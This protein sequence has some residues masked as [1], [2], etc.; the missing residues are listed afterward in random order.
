MDVEIENLV[1]TVNTEL[2]DL[3]DDLKNI[4]TLLDK[5]NL[6]LID[7]QSIYLF[8]L[9]K[10]GFPNQ[11]PFHERLQIAVSNLKSAFEQI[12]G[13]FDLSQLFVTSTLAFDFET[14]LNL[15]QREFR[16]P[17]NV[18]VLAFKYELEKVVDELKNK[19]KTE[20]KR[21]EGNI[22]QD[23]LFKINE[24][25]RESNQLKS[26]IFKS[27]GYKHKALS[28]SINK[29]FDA[30]FVRL[31]VNRDKFLKDLKFLIEKKCL[32]FEEKLAQ[33]NEDLLWTLKVYQRQ[34][35]LTNPEVQQGQF[36]FTILFDNVAKALI[37]SSSSSS[38]GKKRREVVSC[39]S[40]SFNFNS[41]TQDVIIR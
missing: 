27:L 5:A 28:I 23:T 14:R 20:L 38:L 31:N 41:F 2:P 9:M 33:A 16:T 13:Q 25:K 7:E 36:S 10:K 17:Q 8:D 18:E 21:I 39:G 35:L 6:N 11:I 32:L 30:V 3:K 40:N 4:Q 15:F 22:F 1:K 29:V 34:R 37:E 24:L 26:H 19:S 12:Q